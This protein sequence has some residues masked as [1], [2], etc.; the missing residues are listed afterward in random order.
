M[1]NHMLDWIDRVLTA[2]AGVALVM[3]VMAVVVEIIGRS[4]GL[5]HILS[6]PEQITLYMMFLGFFGLVRCFRAEGNIVV[7][8]ATQNLSQSTIKR[9]DGFWTVL[10]AIVVLPMAVLTFGDGLTFHGYGQ[11]SEVLG[12]SPL[13]YH[14][15]AAVGLALTALACVIVGFRLM[16]NARQASATGSPKDDHERDNSNS[17]TGYE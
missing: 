16:L 7:D 2:I 11:R 13:V 15:I 3:M 6:T 12:I 10:T 17:G 1:I 8:V 5:F 4:L 9:I 14:T